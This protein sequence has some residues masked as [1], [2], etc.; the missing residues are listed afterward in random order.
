MFFYS[1]KNNE[2]IESYTVYS[3]Y[4]HYLAYEELKSLVMDHQSIVK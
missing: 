3:S 2:E 1:D 4:E